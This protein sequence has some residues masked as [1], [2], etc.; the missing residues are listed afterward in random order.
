MSI[1][2]LLEE[3]AQKW[4][5]YFEKK[6]V[7]GAEDVFTAITKALPIELKASLQAQDLE[8]QGSTGQGNIT[9]APWIAIFDR[10]LTTSATTGY[11]VVYLYSVDVETVTLCIAFGT[12]QF[13][14]QFG[15]GSK[16]FGPM[17]TAAK[18]LQDLYR[19]IAPPQFMIG[20]IDL[21]AKRT[22]KQHYAYEQSAIF[23]L[24]PYRVKALPTEERL[25]LD[26]TEIV[27]LYSAIVSDPLTPSLE[28]LLQ[29]TIPE[30]KEIARVSSRDFVARAPKKMQN[31]AGKNL[32]RRRYSPESRKV[33]DAGERAVLLHEKK[34]LEKAHRLD[35]ADAVRWHPEHGEFPGWD[36]TSYEINGDEIY[37]E[38][39]ATI[40]KSVSAVDLTANE[41]MAALQKNSQYHIYI[42]TEALSATP[43]IEVLRNPGNYVRE[44][45]LELAPIVYEFSLVSNLEVP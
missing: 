23:S 9:A 3:I 6:R 16:P 42:V 2:S 15:T 27:A 7:S 34:K 30:P 36:I 1:R 33:G 10:R 20:P 17:R 29:A 41:W 18:R 25:R 22:Q 38:V 35:L 11:Y 40:G 37:I 14:N 31:R 26:L 43:S 28:Q 32:R 21:S 19:E 45:K 5:A 44:G 24:P 13:E 8:V 12:A 39:K 4:P